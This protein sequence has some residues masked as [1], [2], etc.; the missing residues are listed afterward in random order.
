MA[1][2]VYTYIYIYICAHTLFITVEHLGIERTS[3]CPSPHHEPC[4][5]VLGALITLLGQTVALQQTVKMSALTEL[6][7]LVNDHN[8]E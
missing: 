7:T 3:D 6:L 1:H 8:D 2:P 4:T 5:T